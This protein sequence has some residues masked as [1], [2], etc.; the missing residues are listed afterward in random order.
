MR[1]AAVAVTALMGSAYVLAQVAPQP[2]QPGA[3]RP[4][5]Q[6]QPGTQQVQPNTQQPAQTQQPNQPNRTNQPVQGFGQI[7]S[8]FYQTP[9]INRELNI[10]DEQMRRLNEAYTPIR[11]RYTSE[12]DK[13]QQMNEEQRRARL[14]ELRRSWTTDVDKSLGG[15][16]D[17][18]QMARYRQLEMQH[19]GIDVFSD[20]DVQRK[21]N[22]TDEQQRKFKE[23]GDRFAKQRREIDKLAQ[24]NREEA[25]KRYQ[26]YDKDL[27]G[28]VENILTEPQ[29]KM[30]Q[31]MSGQ[32][33]EFQPNFGHSNN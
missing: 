3:Q 11:T 32:P 8:P 9:G 13:L 6:V 1:M 28:S 20:P 16:L 5:Q 18:K 7:N 24:T 10:T 26:T 21:L 15:V 31:D 14:Q 30:W 2:Q 29:R 22:L 33:Y 4:N 19:R 25:T 27:R 17:Q 12:F 23:L